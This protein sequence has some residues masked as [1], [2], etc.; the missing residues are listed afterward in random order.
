TSRSAARKRQESRAER[1]LHHRTVWRGGCRGPAKIWRRSRSFRYGA[2]R[3]CLVLCSKSQGDSRSLVQ[4][5]KTRWADDC[6]RTCQEPRC[7]LF[8]CA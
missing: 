8:D 5:V 1:C 7:N 6:L 4:A 3:P 2:Q